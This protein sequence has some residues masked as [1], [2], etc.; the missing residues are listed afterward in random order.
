M[1]LYSYFSSFGGIDYIIP[2]LYP[3]S[4]ILITFLI[5]FIIL[6]SNTSMAKFIFNRE[7]AIDHRLEWSSRKRDTRG[8][9]IDLLLLCG[10]L[11]YHPE[12][13]ILFLDKLDPT[14]VLLNKVFEKY[15]LR[16]V[17][18]TINGRI[19]TYLVMCDYSTADFIKDTGLDNQL[20]LKMPDM[21]YM[22]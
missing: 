18:L 11:P 6:L 12:Y 16:K 1:Y 20:Y 8:K 7:L 9:R 5:A 2:K 4:Y 21:E 14:A 3:L 22:W 19:S 10:R 13:S 17:R 15:N